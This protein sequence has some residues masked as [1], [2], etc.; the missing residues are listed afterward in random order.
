LL[1]QSAEAVAESLVQ[2]FMDI[3]LPAFFEIANGTP[4]SPPAPEKTGI[5]I[6][7]DLLIKTW[8]LH[9]LNRCA[10]LR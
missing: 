9:N 6:Q 7:V 4:V 10:D 2:S 3:A 8:R 1:P 5:T